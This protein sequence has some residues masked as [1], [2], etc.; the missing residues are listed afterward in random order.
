MATY[1]CQV[2]FRLGSSVSC[3][4]MS[5]NSFKTEPLHIYIYIYICIIIIII[6]IINI[7][8]T[9]SISSS[10][11]WSSSL[12]PLSSF[13]YHHH[14]HLHHYQLLLTLANTDISTLLEPLQPLVQGQPHLDSSLLSPS[15]LSRCRHGSWPNL[16]LKSDRNIEKQWSI[17]PI[18]G[19]LCIFP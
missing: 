11:S 13:I 17:G 15:Q 9:V 8:L 19:C 3:D 18:I 2:L 7:M 14:L 16:Y 12:S 4:L 5:Q 10:L 6:I 1:L